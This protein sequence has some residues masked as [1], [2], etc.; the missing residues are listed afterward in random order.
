MMS[1]K[2]FE[3]LVLNS[4]R[5]LTSIGRI[6]LKMGRGGCWQCTGGGKDPGSGMRCPFCEHGEWFGVEAD[7][8]VR[9][10]GKKLGCC[11]VVCGEG[12]T[13]HMPASPS[14]VPLFLFHSSFGP[15]SLSPGPYCSQ[16]A[17]CISL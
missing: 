3:H 1:I 12:G 8:R 14:P 13:T 4:S 11:W 10:C 7:R 9:M 16:P 5:C 6:G 15:L 2:Y 17:F